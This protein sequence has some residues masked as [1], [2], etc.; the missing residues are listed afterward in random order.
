MEARIAELVALCIVV[1]CVVHG[2]NRGLLMEVYS[3]VKII[4]IIV[5]TFILSALILPYIP[6]YIP[7]RSGVSYSISVI[8]ATIIIA[9][10]DHLLKL[11]TKIPVLSTLDRVGGALIGIVIGIV[12]DWLAVVFIIKFS[13]MDWAK[14]AAAAIQQSPLLSG[15]LKLNI[16][17]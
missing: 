13:D 2:K 5:G 3:L 6:D 7:G 17:A 14:Q 15:L 10:L 1:A 4:L 9:F 16:F 12:L 8:L 11:I